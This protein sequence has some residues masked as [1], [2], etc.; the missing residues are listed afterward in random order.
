QGYVV[1]WSGWDVTVGAGSG[2]L[3]ITVP[4]ATN[5]D[6]SPIVGP[7]L[8][9]FVVDGATP[10][11]RLSYPPPTTHTA[12][13][14]LRGRRPAT[15][16]PVALPPDGWEYVDSRSVRLL[17]AGTLFQQGRLYDLVYPA[18][19]PLVAGLAFAATRDFVAFLHRV[20]ADDLGTP[21]PVAG[22]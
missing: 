9:E 18:Q 4:V 1:A 2:A 7:S 17:P 15:D 21:N 22:R 3:S 8:E 13:A 12:A 16:P 19:D 6:S 5:T 10:T 11:N 14:T 20:P